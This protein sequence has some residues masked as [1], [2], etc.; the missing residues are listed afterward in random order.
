MNVR[1]YLYCPGHSAKSF[2]DYRSGDSVLF[3]ILQENRTN[4]VCTER[5]A[6]I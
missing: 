6:E 5:E 4:R 1:V 2:S 3:R